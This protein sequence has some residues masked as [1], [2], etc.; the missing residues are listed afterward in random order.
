LEPE[1]NPGIPRDVGA[2]DFCEMSLAGQDSSV[3]AAHLTINA[4]NHLSQRQTLLASAAS[5]YTFKTCI[6]VSIRIAV[7][8]RE[9]LAKTV[10]RT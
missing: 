10:D 6:V 4:W 1:D 8:S 2:R 5:D 3:T 7:S 9:N